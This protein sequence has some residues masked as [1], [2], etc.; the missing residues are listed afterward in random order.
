MCVK[1]DDSCKAFN[2][3]RLRCMECYPGYQLNTFGECVKSVEEVTDVNCA[4]WDGQNCKRCS[5]GSAFNAFGICVLLDSQCKEYDQ[6]TK[7]CKACYSGYELN[8]QNSC[9]KS[10]IKAVSDPL[11]AEWQNDICL[12]CSFGSFF[13]PTAKLCTLIDSSCK[14]FN[15]I[16][17][18]CLNCYDGYELNVFGDCVKV[19]EE[20]SDVNCAEWKGK[21]CLRCSFG[22][23]FN[24]FGKYSVLDAQCKDYD[25]I[26][27]LCKAFYPGY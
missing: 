16:T 12:R 24:N 8:D 7:L 23:V 25:F 21:I 22:A 14:S 2:F 17:G 4:E 11:C 18:K 27:G 26:T 1:I 19:I 5:F 20:L 9:I 3:I 15:T 6:F 10:A 13:N